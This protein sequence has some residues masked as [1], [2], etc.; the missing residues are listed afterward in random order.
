M[1]DININLLNVNDDSTSKYVNNLLQSNF[2]P[3]ISLP[4]R[5]CETTATLID[6]IMVKVPRKFIQS[7]VS[8]GNLLADIT[9]HLPNFVLIN[10]K[11]SHSKVILLGK[12]LDGVA[13]C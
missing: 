3:C 5:F 1:G 4:T 8:A 2:I 13:Y 9:D 6:H 10:T 7:K 11:I 12:P